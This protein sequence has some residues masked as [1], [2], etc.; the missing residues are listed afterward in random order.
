VSYF[1]TFSNLVL[2]FHLPISYMIFNFYVIKKSHF[3]NFSR[4]TTNR[5]ATY[6]FGKHLYKVH[7]NFAKY[8]VTVGLSKSVQLIREF[9]LR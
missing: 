8:L 3:K 2:F 1:L 9:S 5:L 7:T 6:Q 4:P